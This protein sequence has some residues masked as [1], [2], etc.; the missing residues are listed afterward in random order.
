M[1][2]RFRYTLR[3]LLA[4]VLVAAIFCGYHMVWIRQRHAFLA[5]Q[6]VHYDGIEAELD[7]ARK[8]SMSTAT[9]NYIHSSS[10]KQKSFNFLWLFGEQP[11]PSVILV[12]H[13][14]PVPPD[15][16]SGLANRL[17]WHDELFPAAV[18]EQAHKLFP[19][20]AIQFTVYGWE[21]KQ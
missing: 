9:V 14:D 1:K 18:I 11:C 19:E 15:G 21:P 10:P 8:K 16:R 20:A 5:E 6:Q 4:I 3:F 17:T 7:Q 2:F 12:F 13:S